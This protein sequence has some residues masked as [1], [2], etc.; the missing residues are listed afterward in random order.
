MPR[1][2]ILTETDGPFVKID[3]RIVMPW[4]AQRASFELANMWK[5]PVEEVEHRLHDNLRK[6]LSN[7]N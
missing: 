1:E 2:R 5:I 6:L 4:D 3:G 7:Q